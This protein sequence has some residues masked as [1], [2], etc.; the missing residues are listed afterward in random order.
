MAVP[1]ARAGLVEARRRR[2]HAAPWRRVQAGH[3]HPLDAGTTAILIL[4]GGE[5]GG[6]QAGQSTPTPLPLAAVEGPRRHAGTVAVAAAAKEVQ[7]RSKTAV[8]RPDA[9]LGLL[10]LFFMVTAWRVFAVLGTQQRFVDVRQI[11]T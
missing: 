6:A 11:H 10:G 1:P 2:V 5:A 8:K 3:R 7:K 9:C 4:D